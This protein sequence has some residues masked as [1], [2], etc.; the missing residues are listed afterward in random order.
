MSGKT[1]HARVKKCGKDQDTSLGGTGYGANHTKGRGRQM[2]DLI[3]R[4]AAIDAIERES[5]NVDSRYFISERIVHTSDAVEA[6]SLLPSAQPERGH[7]IEI[8]NKRGVVIAIKCDKCSRF[9]KRGVKSDFCPNCGAD[10]RG[11]QDE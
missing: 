2:S 10:M 7:W 6:I 3:S 5:R 11:D 9:P 1:E 4:Q 8:R